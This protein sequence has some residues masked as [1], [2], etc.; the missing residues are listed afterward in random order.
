MTNK[1]TA[2]YWE[3][4][5]RQWQ[6]CL[7]YLITFNQTYATIDAGYSEKGASVQGGRLLSHVKVAAAIA[8]L[9]E[10][11]TKRTLIDADWL[12]ERLAAEATADVADLYEEDGVTLKPISEWPKIWRTG[13][14]SGVKTKPKMVADIYG[15]IIKMAVTD[16]TLS[17]RVR[18]LELIGKHV[19]VQGFSDKVDHSSK[20]G[21]MTPKN[22]NEFYTTDQ[23]ST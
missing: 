6:F 17:D 10:E 8:Y 5:D 20:D 3:L 1:M 16:I 2:A 15:N 7:E 18:R 21:T 11:R 14:V 9:I 23:S 22:F 4:S 13:L 12:L 19:D